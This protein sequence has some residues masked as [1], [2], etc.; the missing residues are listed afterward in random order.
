MENFTPY[1]ALAGGILIGLSVTIMLLFNGRI[2]G[3][4]GMISELLSPKPD[5]WLWRLAFLIG[6]IIGAFCFVYFF[7]EQYSP[8]TDFPLILLIAGG[9]LVGLGTKLGG[10]CTSGHGICGLARFSTRSLAATIIFMLA[11]AITVFIIRH[12]IGLTS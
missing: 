3:I 2:T 10:G 11:G 9:F 1:S 8:R 5:E 12:V 7:P 4:S 6:L